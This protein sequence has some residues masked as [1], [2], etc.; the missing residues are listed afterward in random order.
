MYISFEDP[1][2][3]YGML[4]YPWLGDWA[5]PKIRELVTIRS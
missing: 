5:T 4:F 2:D 1:D 3:I